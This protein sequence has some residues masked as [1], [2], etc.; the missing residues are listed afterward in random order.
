[1][2]KKLDIDW[3]K[4]RSE[5]ITDPEKPN[6]SGF[7][8]AKNIS[9]QTGKNRAGSEKWI[10]SR[11]KHW[12][13]VIT[14]VEPLLKD[15]QV[16]V[17]ARDTAQKL[18]EIGKM[19]Q[20]AYDQAGGGDNLI[21]Y[22]KPSEAVAAYERLEKLERLILG[23]STENIKV[24]DARAAFKDLYQL[25]METLREVIEDPAYRNAVFAKLAVKEPLFANIEQR[26][27]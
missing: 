1:M 22:E 20:A 3:G 7:F 23:E 14:R 17:S 24:E 11:A 5:F 25:M 8:R 21:V 16:V 4:L 9:A 27:N 13:T 15:V 6:L 10:E 12:A 26:L 19:K 2:P 18:Y